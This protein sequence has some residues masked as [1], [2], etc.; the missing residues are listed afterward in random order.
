MEDTHILYELIIDMW[1]LIRDNY[2]PETEEEWETML[3]QGKGIT[4]NPEYKKVRGLAINWI[5]NYV[6]WL[7]R[8]I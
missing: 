3:D 8:K 7:E 5:N 1:R 4:N 6:L 2:K